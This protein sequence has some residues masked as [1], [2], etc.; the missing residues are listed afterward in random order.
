[1]TDKN[2]DNDIAIDMLNCVS[3]MIRGIEYDDAYIIDCKLR[4]LNGLIIDF[5]RVFYI[6]LKNNSYN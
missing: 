5:S 4:E 1:M 3:A 2:N 6:N